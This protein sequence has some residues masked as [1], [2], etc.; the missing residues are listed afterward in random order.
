MT[1][2]GVKGWVQQTLGN[3]NSLWPGALQPF[4][5]FPTPL[6]KLQV[7]FF[8]ACLSPGNLR[9]CQEKP[10][11]RPPASG[12]AGEGAGG[13]QEG[14]EKSSRFFSLQETPSLPHPLGPLRFLWLGL[15][16]EGLSWGKVKARLRSSPAE[17]A[18]RRVSNQTGAG[19]VRK[20]E[21]CPSRISRPRAGQSSVSRFSFLRCP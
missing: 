17:S 2:G 5:P 8:P 15:G 12:G 14:L 4:H 10:P 9:P 6:H 11:S 16:R 13:D 20:K 19:A 18:G 21:F 3:L 1:G 7:L